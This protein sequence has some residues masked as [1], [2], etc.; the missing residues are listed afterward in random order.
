MYTP[1]GGTI[2]LEV[3]S[4]GRNAVIRVCDTGIGIAAEM[5]PRLFDE[6]VGYFAV[7]FDEKSLTATT[8]PLQVLDNVR[9]EGTNGSLQFDVSETGALVYVPGAENQRN[10][11][12]VS[13]NGKETLVDSAW[14]GDFS[15]VALSPDGS[16]LAITIAG[17]DGSSVWVKRL[18]NGSLTRLTL[19]GTSDRPTWTPD[20]R[21]VAYMG[22]RGAGG[23]RTA[24]MRRADGSNDEQLV[25]PKAP[26]LDEVSFSPDGRV[27]ILRTLGTSANSRK[28]LIA[29]SPDSAPRPLVHTDY[30]NYAAVISPNGKW[31]AYN[32]NESGMT[33]IYVQ[34]FPPAGGRWQI[35]T[36]GGAEPSWNP[37]GKELFYLRGDKL[38]AVD[39]K[40]ETGRF[41]PGTPR[42]L[43]EAPVGNAL[44]NV[45]VVSPDGQALALLPS[46]HGPDVP[47][48]VDGDLLPG[49][50]PPL[51]R[52]LGARFGRVEGEVSHGERPSAAH[53][54]T[55]PLAGRLELPRFSEKGSCGPFQAVVMRGHCGHANPP[56]GAFHAQKGDVR[57][58]AP[59]RAPALRRSTRNRSRG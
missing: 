3:T 27:T 38:M 53:C 5:M 58:S 56:K 9:A 29:P 28:L 42:V 20:G 41:E 7:T 26:Q 2:R 11:V 12:W 36:E 4:D 31:I 19:T 24:W 32:S 46:L 48:E 30:D 37:N 13:R 52:R 22:S 43:F 59:G 55:L 23:K 51:G 39:V 8:E 1:P 6:R 25:N 16:R 57:R 44:R 14:T 15:D 17:N 50:E 33:E 34:N 35:S 21:S 18:P 47:P 10:I 45:Y 40:T 54:R 49:V